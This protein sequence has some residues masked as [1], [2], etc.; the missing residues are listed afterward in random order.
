MHDI[1]EEIEGDQG[2]R[3]WLTA[4]LEGLLGVDPGDPTDRPPVPANESAAA[5]AR[6]LRH[7]AETSSVIVAIEDL[8]WSEPALREA[9]ADLLDEVAASPVLIVCTA[10]PELV[11]AAWLHERAN[12]ST[13]LLSELT[14][15]ETRSLL[16]RLI[17]N[18][19][20]LLM[21]GA[22]YRPRTRPGRVANQGTTTT[23]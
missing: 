18:S 20:Q 17:N 15:E 5:C 3:A 19:H 22:S 16:D 13:V 23:R 2:E 9:V 1:A 14:G 12:A 7:A 8:H 6:L 10:R 21:A 11:E 4:R